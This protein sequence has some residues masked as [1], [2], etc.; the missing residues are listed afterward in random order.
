MKIIASMAAVTAIAFTGFVGQAHAA[1]LC[2]LTGTWTDSLGVATATIK[3]KHGTLAVPLLCATPYKFAITD[4]TKTGFTVS[5]TNKTKSCGTFAAMPTFTGC[6]QFGGSV[7]I[8]GQTVSDTFTKQ[9]PARHVEP[10][11]NPALNSE[12]TAGIR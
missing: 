10:A 12:L 9:T 8:N 7:T 4:E 3:G 11:L 2:K 6:D 1:G 5:G